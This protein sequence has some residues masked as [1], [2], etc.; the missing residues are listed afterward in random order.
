MLLCVF[1]DLTNQVCKYFE[2]LCKT[3]LMLENL[4]RI[5][6]ILT[7]GK[8]GL[9]LLFLKKISSHTHAFCS[10]I[11]M[12]WGVSKMCLWFF[13]NCVFPQKFCEPLSASIDPICFSINQNCLF[14]SI[15][16]I[17]RI[18]FL[19]IYIWLVQT[20]FSKAFQNFFS[21]SLRLGKAPQQIFFHFPPNFLQGFS[22]YKPVCS[23]YPFFCIVFHVFMHYFMFFG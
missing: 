12:L 19:K 11:S 18:R 2:F 21:L 6:A 20:T 14:V 15:N 22:L 23:Y 8:L 4:W 1:F 10:S 13:H 17:S 16:W 3:D 7:L 9:K 5:Y